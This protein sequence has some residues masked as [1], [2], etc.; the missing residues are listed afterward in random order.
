MR[1]W[2]Q[3]RLTLGLTFMGLPLLVT[4]SDASTGQIVGAHFD[5]DPVLG[6]DADV[7]LP[8]FAGDGGE[9]YVLIF[10]LDSKHRVRQR[11]Y[12]F[13]LDFYHTIF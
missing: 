8:D 2:L 10:K 6:E 5:Y 7:V 12:D 9:H 4:I 1:Q 11:L 3:I 13:A